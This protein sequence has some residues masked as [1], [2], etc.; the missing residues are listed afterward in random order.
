MC[1]GVSRNKPFERNEE[2][3][4][5]LIRATSV[6][7]S[8][9]TKTVAPPV[10]GDEVKSVTAE[11]SRRGDPFRL[12]VSRVQPLFLARDMDNKM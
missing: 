11:V 12:E 9:A 6:P 10:S 3:V 4:A 7:R 5:M 2:G 8:S 1:L